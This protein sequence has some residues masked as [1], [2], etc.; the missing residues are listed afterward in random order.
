M[1]ASDNYSQDKLNQLRK[2]FP[3][4][5]RECSCT[6]PPFNA[7]PAYLENVFRYCLNSADSLNQDDF[8]PWDIEKSLRNKFQ[9]DPS[10]LAVSFF[11]DYY[12]IEK[13]QRKYPAFKNKNIVKGSIKKKYGFSL[14]N[15]KTKHID[16]WLYEDSTPW[17]DYI[18]E[19]HN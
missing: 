10:K 15:D 3:A 14:K 19:V 11:S 18:D 5:F 2:R 7:R 13:M 4:R 17:I 9:Q 16:L 12:A 1:N 6:C 8:L